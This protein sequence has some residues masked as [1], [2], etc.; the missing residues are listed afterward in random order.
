MKQKL[1][2]SILFVLSLASAAQADVTVE[3]RQAALCQDE[4]VRLDDIAKI[5]GD[6][7]SAARVRKVFLGLAPEPGD[8]REIT[9][10]YI[11]RRLAQLGLSAGVEFTGAE[12]VLISRNNNNAKSASSVATKPDAGEQ[13]ELKKL[14][15]EKE[16]L[17]REKEDKR[18][19]AGAVETYLRM[20]LNRTDL[21]TEVEVRR[22]VNGLPEKSKTLEVNKIRS[23]Q[24][25]GQAF[26]KFKTIDAS[27]AV[28]FAT[29]AQIVA[30]VRADVLVLQRDLRKGEL[31]SAADVAVMKQNLGG[32]ASY[33]PPENKQVEGCQASKYLRANDAL[34]LGDLQTPLVIRR[35]S[36][37]DV[38]TWVGDIHIQHYALA[39]GD[40]RE[41]DLIYVKNIDSGE[42]YMALAVGFNRV[43]LPTS[44]NGRK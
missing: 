26:V 34:R 8:R 27:G 36:Q 43:S 41:G 1:M 44:E 5:S 39:L 40:A 17:D 15:V 22:I 11:S 21:E 12:T 31:V 30:V 29:E 19:I 37:V 2:F 35:G 9:R 10:D 18:E 6:E 28:S 16:T 7:E 23:G 42:R 33:L 4:Y 24:L 3:L 38:D 25:P 13:E 14:A 20:S 32:G